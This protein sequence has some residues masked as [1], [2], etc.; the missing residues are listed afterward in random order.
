MASVSIATVHIIPRPLITS[1]TYICPWYLHVLMARTRIYPLLIR[2]M[3]SQSHANSVASQ[4]PHLPQ[5]HSSHEHPHDLVHICSRLG[6]TSHLVHALQLLGLTRLTDRAGVEMDTAGTSW[7]AGLTISAQLSVAGFFSIG[8]HVS[9]DNKGFYFEFSLDI[10][11]LFKL[12]VVLWSK[13][14]FTICG[15]QYGKF[16]RV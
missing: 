10:L 12:K 16:W 11:S 7:N 2:H 6:L 1:S 5:I 13:N 9:L 8:A 14:M 3:Y 15:D 4:S